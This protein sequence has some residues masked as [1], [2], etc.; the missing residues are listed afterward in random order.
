LIWD[1]HVFL[2]NVCR[3]KVISQKVF[4]QNF[5]GRTLV[6]IIITVKSTKNN[7]NNFNSKNECGTNARFRGRKKQK[8]NVPLV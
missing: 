7:F 1:H 8:I 5:S 2:Q 6:G 4:S 3:Q